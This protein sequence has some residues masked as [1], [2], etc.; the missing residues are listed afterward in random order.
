MYVCMC[1]MCIPGA[2]GQKM[3]SEAL[4]L[5]LWIVVNH[6]VDAGNQTLVQTVLTAEP[7]VQASLSSL[8]NAAC[9][10]SSLTYSF[11]CNLQEVKGFHYLPKFQSPCS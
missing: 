7:L 9:V 11:L 5:E 6:H 10:L 4:E 8:D 2:R 1:T 3:V